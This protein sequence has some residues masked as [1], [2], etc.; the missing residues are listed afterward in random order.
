[1]LV[2]SCWLSWTQLSHEQE[3]TPRVQMLTRKEQ[4]HL[5]PSWVVL[6]LIFFL[7]QKLEVMR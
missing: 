3:Y 7:F 2:E 4:R 6:K 1:M 5:K